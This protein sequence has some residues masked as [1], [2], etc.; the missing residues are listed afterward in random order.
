MKR[1]F[2]ALIAIFLII[3][4]AIL[5]DVGIVKA[6]TPYDTLIG[7]HQ[8]ET[9]DMISV[10]QQ[11]SYNFS[12]DWYTETLL[13]Y[14]V[15]KQQT[16]GRPN[17]IDEGIA[18][19]KQILEDDNSNWIVRKYGDNQFNIIYSTAPDAKLVFR[20][21]QSGHQLLTLQTT[22][23]IHES[24]AIYYDPIPNSPNRSPNGLYISPR[25]S[26]V[27]FSTHTI[28]NWDL[29]NSTWTPYPQIF[30][31]TFPVEYP[32]EY[33]GDEIQDSYKPY[34]EIVIDYF[35]SITPTQ[36]DNNKQGKITFGYDQSKPNINLD[37][38]GEYYLKKMAYNWSEPKDYEISE[39][40]GPIQTYKQT[41]DLTGA[42][43]YTIYLDPEPSCDLLIEKTNISSKV[44]DI[45][46]D[47]ETIRQGSS[48]LCKIGS[49]DPCNN[50]Q[51]GEESLLQQLVDNINLDLHGFEKLLTAPLTFLA[52]T[53]SK[54]CQPL[55]LPFPHLGNITAP[56]MTPIYKQHFDPWFTAFQ[57]IVTGVF[58][59]AIAIN[60]IATFKNIRNP[61]D[62]KIEVAKL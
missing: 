46:W 39:I 31:S 49:P 43:Y 9:L 4:G 40:N 19:L 44:M 52:A 48:N 15:Y 33:E 60:F 12:L 62:D 1:I 57:T 59:Y 32:P 25:N 7:N 30:L 11:K 2:L 50:I 13:A 51:P 41:F 20:T 47:G 22:G 56:C 29:L 58:M 27:N 55:N 23:Q 3:I 53:E 17:G 36:L 5:Y 8:I 10:E 6:A 28:P 42:G 24:P 34:D 45:Y 35:W 18:H 16:W 14:E 61:Q 54:T 38:Q 21:N 26:N 37:C